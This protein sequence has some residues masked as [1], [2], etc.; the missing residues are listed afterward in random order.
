[1]RLYNLVV[2]FGVRAKYTDLGLARK[3][4][5]LANKNHRAS[6]TKKT[7][8]VVGNCDIDFFTFAIAKFET[9][10]S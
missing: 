6:V 10:K 8:F 9:S 4:T 1:M 5:R 7:S 3:Y 2:Y